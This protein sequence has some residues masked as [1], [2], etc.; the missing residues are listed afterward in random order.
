MEVDG[1]FND[2]LMLKNESVK[3]LL[4][5]LKAKRGTRTRVVA[6]SVVE[7]DQLYGT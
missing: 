2:H 3:K 7:Q 6:R 4:S 5:A 1:D